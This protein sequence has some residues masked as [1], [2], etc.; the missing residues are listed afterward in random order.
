MAETPLI[1]IKVSN[2]DVDQINV[3]HE[4][5]CGWKINGSKD[6]Q[7]VYALDQLQDDFAC[8]VRVLADYV[9]EASVWVLSPEMRQLSPFHALALLAEGNL[10]RRPTLFGRC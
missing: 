6:G 7:P 9:D 8:L 2:H 1:S 3:Y 4:A 5:D 10:A